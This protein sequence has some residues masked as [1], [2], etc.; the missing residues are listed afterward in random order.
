MSEIYRLKSRFHL[1]HIFIFFWKMFFKDGYTILNKE[2]GFFMKNFAEGP[3]MPI[4]LGLTMAQ[5]LNAMNRFTA[6]SPQQKQKM[7]DHTHQIN[8]R[9]EMR[10]FVDQFARG[11]VDESGASC[12]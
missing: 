5:N 7:I 12:N 10:A 1:N 3:E 2:R 9:K 11:E 6:L 8:S 4:G